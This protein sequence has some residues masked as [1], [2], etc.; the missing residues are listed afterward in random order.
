[1]IRIQV[2]VQPRAKKTE[3]Y[4]WEDQVLKLRVTAAAVEGAA[5]EA[6]LRLLADWLD[7]PRRSLVLLRGQRSRHKLI[8][9]ESD[10]EDRLRQRLEGSLHL[11]SPHQKHIMGKKD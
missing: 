1:M 8:G 6:C 2:K 11:T 4:G 10:D 9:I 5:N 7:V 3:V